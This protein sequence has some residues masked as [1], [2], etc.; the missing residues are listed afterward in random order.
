MPEIP[1]PTMITEYRV[2]FSMEIFRQ[3]DS[4]TLKE[5]GESEFVCEYCVGEKGRNS[6]SLFT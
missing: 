3:E 4:G 5:R 2:G 1:A 6:G